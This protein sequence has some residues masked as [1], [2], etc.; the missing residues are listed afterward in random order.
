MFNE[1]FLEIVL[2]DLNFRLLFVQVLFTALI[3]LILVF[4]KGASEIPFDCGCEIVSSKVL[5]GGTP[6]KYFSWFFTE[7]CDKNHQNL[8]F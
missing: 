1:T 3:K 4:W 6:R 5:M 8:S 2:I 7:G